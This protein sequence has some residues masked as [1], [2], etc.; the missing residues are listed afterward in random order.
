MTEE[1]KKSENPQIGPKGVDSCSS[2]RLETAHRV[3]HAKKGN[4]HKR[5]SSHLFSK[6]EGRTEDPDY[7]K[8]HRYLLRMGNEKVSNSTMEKRRLVGSCY[9]G[10]IPDTRLALLECH[11]RVNF[12]LRFSTKGAESL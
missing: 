2:A 12:N 8:L 5:R 6:E 1:M 11:P 3:K 4:R 7:E 9:G 10:I